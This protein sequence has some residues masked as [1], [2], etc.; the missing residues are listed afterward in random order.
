MK[1]EQAA[2]A[3]LPRDGEARAAAGRGLGRRSPRSPRGMGVDSPT[4]A[5]HDIYEGRRDRLAEV[6]D[7]IRLHDGQ[8]GALVAIDG[9]IAVLDLVSRPE[10]FA[11]LHGPLVQGYALDALEAPTPTAP[12][13]RRS[14][15]VPRRRPRG[16]RQRARRHRPRPRRPLRGSRGRGRRR[17]GRGDELIQ[18]TAFADA[19]ADS[20]HGN[21]PGGRSSAH[22]PARGVMCG[23][24]PQYR[25]QDGFE[26]AKG[27]VCRHA[28]RVSS[29]M[30]YPGIGRAYSRAVCGGRPEARAQHRRRDARRE[31]P[32]LTPGRSPDGRLCGRFSAVCEDH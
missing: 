18:L 30:R 7:A 19:G 13:A 21:A 22:P 15:G 17:A 11:A 25:R 32:G 24:T 10:C 31:W 1:N 28:G 4:G 9:E 3:A 2:R 23:M 26:T 16:P 12:S 14:G 20:G 5:M 27:G 6:R 29:E 8:I